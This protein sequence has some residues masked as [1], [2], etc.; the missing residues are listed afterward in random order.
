MVDVINEYDI[1]TVETDQS[2]ELAHEGDGQSSRS[3]DAAMGS[4]TITAILDEIRSLNKT[5]SIGVG[6]GR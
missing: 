1:V 3:R 4:S 2:I 5:F 6:K